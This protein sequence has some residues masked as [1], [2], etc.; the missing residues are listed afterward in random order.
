MTK[1]R[2]AV[3]AAVLLCGTAY[4]GEQEL[5]DKIKALEQRVAQLEGSALTTNTLPAQTLAFLGKSTLSGYVSSSFFHNFN[6]S[7]P[8]GGYVNKNDQFAANKLKL[9]LGKP[10][11]Y[12]KDKFDIGYR[13]D[14]IVGEDAKFINSF[15]S[16]L[17][18]GRDPICLEQAYVNINVPIGNGLKVAIG[19]MVTL[20]GVEVV[21]ETANPNWTLGNQFL[22]VENT[23]QVGALLSYKFNDK[24]E[25][26][27][28]VFNG[29]D[30]VTDNNSGY[31]YMG[32]INLTLSD[33]TSISLLGY[34]GPEQTGNTSSW[35]KGGEVIV[36]QKVGSKLTLYGQLDYGTEDNAAHPVSGTVAKA[37]W[38]GAGL[39]GVYQFTDKVGLALRG[40]YI[41][42][43]GATRTGAGPAGSSPNVA[44][45]TA[46]LS[47][48]PLPNL[49]VRPEI[50]WDHCEKEPFT[51][52][53]TA[54]SDQVLLGVGVA[55]VF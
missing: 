20:M 53:N 14:L 33:K 9:A 34:G 22:Y 50:R 15:T 40:D 29:W 26:Q 48:T 51:S 16:G 35:R 24:V 23:S 3:A 37:E 47:L 41:V 1:L 7:A 36:T 2:P 52:G 6:D 18:S 4:A 39:W 43:D 49:Q 11:D 25:V 54:K 19:K 30:K 31:S 44:S 45:L 17:G 38:Y 42:D 8:V 27:A 46:T 28:A 12:N 32:K 10:V 5:L 21:E 55:Y 13:A